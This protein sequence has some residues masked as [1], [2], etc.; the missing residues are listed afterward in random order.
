[1]QPD[2]VVKRAHKRGVV[3]IGALSTTCLDDPC[4]MILGLPIG[5][6]P[7]GTQ[8]E[9]LRYALNGQVGL[10]W[11]LGSVGGEVRILVVGR[12]GGGGRRK[13]W[14]GGRPNVSSNDG[15]PCC[16]GIV[17]VCS[18]GRGVALVIDGCLHNLSVV[19]FTT[20]SIQ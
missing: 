1:M 13:V 17:L 19:L 16:I 9:A 2:A 18:S 12:S 15:V 7:R 20:A 8:D 6:G 14:S 10:G 3:K 11:G 4:A 5:E